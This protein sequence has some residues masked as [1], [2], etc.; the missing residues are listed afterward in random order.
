MLSAIKYVQNSIRIF[1][2]VLRLYSF[3]I[4]FNIVFHN[5][6]TYIVIMIITDIF[7][8]FMNVDTIVM[9]TSIYIET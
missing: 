6:Y 3:T 5:G 9:Y 7:E 2:I 8:F 4:K 1:M